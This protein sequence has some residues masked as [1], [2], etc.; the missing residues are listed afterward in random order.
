MTLTLALDYGNGRFV[1]HLFLKITRNKIFSKIFN[2]L[3]KIEVS[4]FVNFRK[5]VP[6]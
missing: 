1:G 6:L 4:F 2:A 3:N 5:K